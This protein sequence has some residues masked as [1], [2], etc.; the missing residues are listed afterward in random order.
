VKKEMRKSVIYIIGTLIVLALVGLLVVV[1]GKQSR[2]NRKKSNPIASLL[3]TDNS[4]SLYAKQLGVE[5]NCTGEGSIEFTHPPMKPEDVSVVLPYGLLA[6]GHV[7]PIDHMYFSPKVFNSP[8]DT[9]PVYAI[10]DG[11]IATI[12]FRAL[13][14]GE[15][16]TQ[17]SA[18]K[19]DYRLDLFYNCTFFSYYDLITS[20][21]P[22]LAAKV[23]TDTTKSWN[24]RVNLPIK[25]G[26]GIGRIGG[27]TLDWAVYNS[28]VTLP[29]LLVP[30]HYD[31]EP[32]KIHTD[33]KSLDYFV[34]PIKTQLYSLLARQVEPRIGKIDYDIEGKLI[35]NWFLEGTN[36]YAGKNSVNEYWG[37]HL[38]VVPDYIDPTLWHFSIGDWQGQP[39][40]FGINPKQDPATVDVNSGLVAYELQ[41]SEYYNGDTGNTW[42]SNE[43]PIR[44]PKSR[45]NG[46]VQ[47]T[48]LLQLIESRKL[49]VETFPGKKMSDVTGFTSNAKMYER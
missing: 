27:Q 15:A 3:N 37:G 35:G 11:T 29:G 44:N 49:K 10:A 9:Y 36:G 25:A 45:V 48:V 12:S 21:S 16:H 30:E 23:P 38:A 47:G 8:P 32:W 33:Y 43:G 31:R 6:G 26:Q 39:Q 5:K 7:T 46:Q 2:S 18:K 28:D 1:F 4:G 17:K 40:Q 20:L 34:E 22:E 42:M 13:N 14:S 19:G 24:E 41:S